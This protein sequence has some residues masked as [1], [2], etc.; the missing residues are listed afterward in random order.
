MA[1]LSTYIITHP[2]TK[3]SENFKKVSD[4]I[5][6]NL[7]VAEDLL[8]GKIESSELLTNKVYTQ[9]V[10]DATYGI[11]YESIAKANTDEIEE[12]QLI[13]SS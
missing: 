1:S 13:K 11:H 5:I 4:S 3:A 7:Q 9:A 2:T 6:S 12:R 10:F 8:N